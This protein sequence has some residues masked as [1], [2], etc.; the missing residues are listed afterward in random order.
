MEN[1]NKEVR[2][3]LWIEAGARRA[4]RFRR[5]DI[6]LEV[7]GEPEDRVVADASEIGMGQG[8]LL[9]EGADEA[10][11][12]HARRS[13]HGFLDEIQAGIDPLQWIRDFPERSRFEFRGFGIEKVEKG[14]FRDLI[15]AFE[16]VEESAFGDTGRGADFIDA[17]GVETLGSHQL[18]AGFDKLALGI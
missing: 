15:L 8:K 17:G 12:S 14:G 7:G 9:G 1:G 6:A 18:H 13:A 3:A 16:I 10:A 5:R 4:S 11:P 2:Q